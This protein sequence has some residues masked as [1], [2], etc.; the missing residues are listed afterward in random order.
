MTETRGAQGPLKGHSS[1]GNISRYFLGHCSCKDNKTVG[2]RNPMILILPP[3]PSGRVSPRASSGG[4]VGRELFSDLKS[5][6]AKKFP[7][8]FPSRGQE[9]A[10]P[11]PRAEGGHQSHC[12]RSRNSHRLPPCQNGRL[13]AQEMEGIWPQVLIAA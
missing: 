1:G 12:E 6:R 2:S 7:H 11:A 10:W 4:R 8:D 9:M 5:Q 13:Q 3:Q